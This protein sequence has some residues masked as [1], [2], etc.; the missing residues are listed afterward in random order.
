[1]DDAI[2]VSREEKKMTMMMMTMIMMKRA[3]IVDIS[4][5]AA[6]EMSKAPPF[7]QTPMRTR[8]YSY[9][10]IPSFPFF[11]FPF[12]CC[13]TCV[14]WRLLNTYRRNPNRES[15]AYAAE[16]KNCSARRFINQPTTLFL[17]SSS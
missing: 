13:A 9:V 10:L 17:N 1:V 7:F 16:K 6:D 5:I 8:R 14:L 4:A 11:F 12:F 2:Y 15:V 3:E